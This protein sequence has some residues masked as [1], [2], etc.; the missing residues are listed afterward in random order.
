MAKDKVLVTGSTGLVGSSLLPRLLE[1]YQ[2]VYSVEHESPANFGQKVRID[3][4]DMKSVRKMLEKLQPNIFINL[5]A[6]TD[7][8]GCETNPHYAGIINHQLVEVLA[9]HIRR[10]QID[11][12]NNSYLLHISTDYVFDGNSGN[13]SET[14]KPN[15]IN[16]YGRTKLLGEKAITSSLFENDW[17]IARISTPFG[18]HARKKTFP[19]YVTERLRNQQK[20]NAIVDQYTT[21]TYT[22]NLSEML[23]DIIKKRATGIFHVSGASRLSRF[24]QALRIAKVLNLDASLISGIYSGSMKWSAKRPKDSSLNV[25]RANKAL[26]HKPEDFNISLIKFARD[27]HSHIYQST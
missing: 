18:I 27:L 21:P 19:L 2:E 14:D 4:A 16:Q 12:N 26:E 7:V 24:E 11:N 5:A 3:L 9:H 1:E 20:V 23:I 25:N 6:F 15:P 10:S 22:N 17:C 8:D 13:Y